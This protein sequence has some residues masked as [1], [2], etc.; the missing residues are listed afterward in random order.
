[1]RW[2]L[3]A[4]IAV[5]L[6]LASLG[7]WW[8]TLPRTPEEFF[9]IRCATCHKLPDLS[10]YKRDEIAGIVRTMRTKNGADKVIDDDE[11]EIITRYLEGMKE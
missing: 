6:A 1:M 3:G 7:W 5:L 11:A 9:K 8:I 2:K 10:G 4:S